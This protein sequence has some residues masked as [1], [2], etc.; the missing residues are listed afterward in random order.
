MNYR[1]YLHVNQSI[2]TFSPFLLYE[3]RPSEEL[4][5]HNDVHLWYIL[6][7]YESS[8]PAVVV[9]LRTYFKHKKYLKI[10]GYI[11]LCLKW[12]L[13]FGIYKLAQTRTDYFH[14]NYLTIWKVSRNLY[15][16]VIF[17]NTWFRLFYLVQSCRVLPLSVFQEYMFVGRKNNLV[18]KHK[19]SS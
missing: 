11:F 18:W 16:N 12:Y 1:K 2:S 3:P 15:F 8:Q 10:G 19:F 9:R 6:V 17:K 7:N 5:F 13:K 4:S 14:Y